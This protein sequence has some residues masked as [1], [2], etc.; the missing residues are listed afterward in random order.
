MS[1]F[2]KTESARKTPK[3]NPNVNIAHNNISVIWAVSTHSLTGQSQ[4]VNYFL[5]D[6]NKVVNSTK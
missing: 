4:G 5:I 6:E 3:R 2:R 1:F